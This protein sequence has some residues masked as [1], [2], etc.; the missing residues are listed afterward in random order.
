MSI[1]CSIE[2]V[3]DHNSETCARTCRLAFSV[4]P[5]RAY[6]GLR[7]A[8]PDVVISPALRASRSPDAKPAATTIPQRAEG[9]TRQ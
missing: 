9:A 8:S 6:L 2:D 5:R 3:K 4:K 1:I 7:F